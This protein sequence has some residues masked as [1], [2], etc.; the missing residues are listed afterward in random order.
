MDKKELDVFPSQGRIYGKKET[1]EE[2]LNRIMDK[3][4]LEVPN[5]REQKVVRRA[6]IEGKKKVKKTKSISAVKVAAILVGI[7]GLIIYVH[8]YNEAKA[9]IIYDGLSRE[10]SRVVGVDID[11]GYGGFVAYDKDYHKITD[12]PQSVWDSVD[13]SFIEVNRE[14]FQNNIQQGKGGKTQ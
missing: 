5:I 13:P 6:P 11:L 4:E 7:V 2:I 10:D 9:D 8:S 14:I 3:L 1:K 12:I